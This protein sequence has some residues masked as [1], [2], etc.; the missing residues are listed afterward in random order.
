MAY[1]VGAA[2]KAAQIPYPY[3]KYINITLKRKKNDI[4]KKGRVE[5]RIKINKI[6]KR[7]YFFLIFIFKYYIYMYIY[8]FYIFLVYAEKSEAEKDVRKHIFNCAQRVH[9]NTLGKLIRIKLKYI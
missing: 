4:N 2:R 6:N 8:I 1:S 5:E 3:G 7:V 9:Q